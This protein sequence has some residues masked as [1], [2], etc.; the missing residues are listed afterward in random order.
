MLR[1]I[2][3]VMKRI[4]LLTIALAYVLCFLAQ[5]GQKPLWELQT[6]LGL[7]GNPQMQKSV[8][9][10]L[11]LTEVLPQ[12]GDKATMKIAGFLNAATPEQDWVIQLRDVA[13]GDEIMS[14]VA[15]HGSPD[16]SGKYVIELEGVKIAVWRAGPQQVNMASPPVNAAATLDDAVT[17]EPKTW[18][19]GWVN[20]AGLEQKELASQ[21]F[22]LAESVRFSARSQDA[23]ITLQAEAT[24]K[25]ADDAKALHATISEY[26]KLLR[27][28]QPNHAD[29]KQ[30]VVNITSDDDSVSLSLRMKEEQLV[31]LIQEISQPAP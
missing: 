18:L 19:C 7:Q 21:T 30:A 17:L 15:K 6:R 23:M 31:A 28:A 9:S 29:S 22:K 1:I 2:L 16:A 24:L 3:N 27:Q 5:A 11:G 4:S 8:S 26:E 25:N 13:N 14:Q 20:L 12:M 10:L